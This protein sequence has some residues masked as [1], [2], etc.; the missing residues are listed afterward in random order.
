MRHDDLFQEPIVQEIFQNALRLC[1]ESYLVGGAVRDA[2][3][4]ANRIS[5]VDIAVEGDG[6]EIARLLAH[7]LSLQ[8]TFVPLDKERRVGRAVVSTSPATIIDVSSF[9]GPSISDDLFARDFTINSMGVHLWDILTGRFPQAIIDPLEGGEDLRKRILRMSTASSFRDDPLRMLRAFRFEA[10]LN[11]SIDPG[12]LM[13]IRDTAHRIRS[14]SGERVREELAVVLSSGNSHHIVAEMAASGLFWSMFPQL[15]PSLGFEQNRFHHLD[16][17]GHTL[18]A[19]Q[20]LESLFTSLPQYFGDLSGFVLDYLSEQLVPGR[21]RMWLLKLA[22][23]LHDSGK[24]ASLSIDTLGHRRF[25]RHEKISGTIASEVG[26]GFKLAS[27]ESSVLSSLV[28]GHMRTSILSS[29]DIS[30]RSILRFCQTFGLDAIG[31]VL[32]H[33]AD[34]SASKGPA[35][36]ADDCKR[37]VVRAKQVL[38]MLIEQERTPLRPLLNGTELMDEFGLK[39]GP[40]L[41]STLRWLVTEQSLGN[42]NNREQAVEAVRRYLSMSQ[43]GFPVND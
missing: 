8:T 6:Y 37:S 7:S 12:T 31:L 30:Q 2:L 10:Q 16:V 20:N 14:V 32:L 28:E 36:S 33:L 41:G 9:K 19:L 42:V 24:P 43:T 40:S 11:F 4:S 5:D 23:L 1:N 29:E 26:A 34:L 17:W 18:L 38:E 13:K 21:Q 3:I 35:R 39:Q 25:L 27:R 15:V 22:V